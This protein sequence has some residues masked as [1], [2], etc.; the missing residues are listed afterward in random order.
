MQT[1]EHSAGRQDITANA[2]SPYTVTFTATA[3]GQTTTEAIT[4]TVTNIDRAPTMTSIGN[5]TVAEAA[6]LS[7][8]SS[9]NR[10][11]RRCNNIRSR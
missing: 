3:N 8:L 9:C 1:Q 7:L 4:I 11:R 6:T 5:K 2:A 10:C